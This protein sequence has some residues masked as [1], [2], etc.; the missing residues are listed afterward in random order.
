VIHGPGQR[1][2][3]RRHAHELRLQPPTIEHHHA[4]WRWRLAQLS[5]SALL[6]SVGLGCGMPVDLGTWSAENCPL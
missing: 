6:S 1:I 5:A 2:D 4:T 3:R